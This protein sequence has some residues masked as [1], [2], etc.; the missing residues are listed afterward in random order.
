MRTTAP[1][2]AERPCPTCGDYYDLSDPG[3]S[4]PHNNH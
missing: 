4:Y 2:V 1:S 3:A